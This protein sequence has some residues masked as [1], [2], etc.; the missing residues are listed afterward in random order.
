ME[1]TIGFG[2]RGHVIAAKPAR[3]LEGITEDAIRAPS[4]ENRLL[5]DDLM[6]CAGVKPAANL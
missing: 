5:N 1:D 3:M 2:R 6:W 4:G